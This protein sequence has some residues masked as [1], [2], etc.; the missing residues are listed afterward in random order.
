MNSSTRVRKGKNNKKHKL[1][2]IKK[3][4]LKSFEKINSKLDTF[5]AFIEFYQRK[6]SIQKVID[7]SHERFHKF[8][9]Y[10]STLGYR[11]FQQLF[12]KLRYYHK[13][14]I[15][16]L[17]GFLEFRLEFFLYRINFV[18]SKYFAKQLLQKRAFAINN[19]SMVN[20]NYL[21]SI[22]DVLTVN[23]F[24]FSTIY[25]NILTRFRIFRQTALKYSSNTTPILFDNPSYTE[26][27]YSLLLVHIIRK[28]K[29]SE[30]FVPN[31]VELDSHSR[32]PSRI[33][34]SYL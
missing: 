4:N 3:S 34:N 28:P 5:N 31:G 23:R 26:I 20:K 10:Y 33:Y 8:R 14:S 6:N 22:N 30:V 24:F 16:S 12:L 32:D 29:P 18:P 1:T 11:Q 13:N 17:I 25:E 9:L 15:S 27:D 7:Y 2:F 19:R 21:M